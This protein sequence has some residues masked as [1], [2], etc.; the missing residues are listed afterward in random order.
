MKLSTFIEKTGRREAAELFGVSY[1]AVCHWMTGV[2]KPSADVAR[3]IVERS[4]VTWKGIYEDPTPTPAP[5]QEAA[6]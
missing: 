4:P 5:S 6:A 2:R 1:A 3:R